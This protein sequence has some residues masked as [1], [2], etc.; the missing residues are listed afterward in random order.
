MTNRVKTGPQGGSSG[1]PPAG[2][3]H[4]QVGTG[5][6]GLAATDA[7][8]GPSIL[9]S[10]AASTYCTGWSYQGPALKTEEHDECKPLRMYSPVD[11]TPLRTKLKAN[12]FRQLG[13]TKV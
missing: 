4:Q 11:N 5:G 2:P 3:P 12:F 10:D 7:M 13:E 6:S 8:L 9:A 1:A